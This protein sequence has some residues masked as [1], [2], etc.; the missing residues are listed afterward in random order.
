MI[1]STDYNQFLTI[2]FHVFLS[3]LILVGTLQAKA[4]AQTNGDKSPQQNGPQPPKPEE[5]S[6]KIEESEPQ[7]TSQTEPKKET[8]LSVVPQTENPL[9]GTANEDELS[10]TLSIKEDY[11][12]DDSYYDGEGELVMDQDYM[13]QDEEDMGTTIQPG[14]SGMHPGDPTKTP[15]FAIANVSCQYAGESGGGISGNRRI[16]RSEAELRRAAECITR[17]QTFQNVSDQFNIPIST[18]RYVYF[19][20]Y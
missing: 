3:L 4:A 8:N 15:E 20:Y 17:G 1:K 11:D 6:P 19:L 5:K 18:I 12:G 9:N 7:S 2:G 13:D 16:R 14:T 10:T